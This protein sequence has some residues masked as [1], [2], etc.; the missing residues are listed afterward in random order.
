[1]FFIKNYYPLLVFDT[2][3]SIH[4]LQRVSKI[5]KT[6]YLKIKSFEKYKAWHK[7]DLEWYR[8]RKTKAK[9]I[10]SVKK[11]YSGN[12][13]TDKLSQIDFPHIPI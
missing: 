2:L 9:M 5:L 11:K 7:I 8:S 1:M 12:Y 3:K 6:F 10:S 4:T 13:V